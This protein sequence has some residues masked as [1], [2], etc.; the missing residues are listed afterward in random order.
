LGFVEVACNSLGYFYADNGY[1]F[2]N[3]GQFKSYGSLF[4]ANDKLTA[5]KNGTSIRFFKNGVDL[6]EAI[7]NCEGEMYPY[8]EL[9][10]VGSSVMIVP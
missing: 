2:Y 1:V 3:G 8:V 9:F 4:E 5:I 6:G 10:K 7:N